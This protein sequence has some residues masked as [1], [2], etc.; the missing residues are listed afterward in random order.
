MAKRKRNEDN[1]KRQQPVQQQRAEAARKAVS[2]ARRS[3]SVDSSAEARPAD[4]EK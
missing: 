1:S 3:K 2:Q 4:K